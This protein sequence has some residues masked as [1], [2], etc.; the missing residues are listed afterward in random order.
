MNDL[1]AWRKQLA[2]NPRAAVIELQACVDKRADGDERGGERD[3]LF[4]SLVP[5]LAHQTQLTDERSAISATI[6]KLKRSGQPVDQAISSVSD[7]SARL[8]QTQERVD[9]L[10]ERALRQAGPGIDSDAVAMPGTSGVDAVTPTTLAGQVPEG[11]GQ[12]RHIASVQ[13]T[14][15]G[16]RVVRLQDTGP[17]GRAD[18]DDWNRYVAAHSAATHYHQYAWRELIESRFAANCVYLMARDADGKVVGVLSAVIMKSHLFGTFALSM[19]YLIYGGPLAD[20]VSVSEVL[21]ARLSS[22]AG[23]AGASRTE[24]RETQPRA[25][26]STATEKVSMIKVLPGTIAELNAGLS[27]KVRSQ[28]RRAAREP[29]TFQLGGSELVEG[30]YRVFSEKMRDLGTPVYSRAFF[31]DILQRFS[32]SARI[33]MLERHGEVV[34]AALIIRFRDTLEVPWAASR[35]KYDASAVNMHLYHKLLETAQQEGCRYFDFGRS[36]RDAPTFRFKRQWGAEPYPLYWHSLAAPGHELPE[37]TGSGN[38]MKLAIRA[39]QYL[40]L[41]VA[42][43]LGPLIAPKLPW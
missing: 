23:E 1:K 22:F 41:P 18:H 35:R 26:W 6:G 4:E 11:P 17:H 36:T 10:I 32:D 3:E 37:G 33:A 8:K 20:D 14:I 25:H 15:E 43:V 13:T 16:V 7:L 21:A 34:A 12:F 24:L 28:A 2:T 31:D 42:N 39:W 29:L 5:L 38:V 9:D 27:A 19:P 30:F 40:P